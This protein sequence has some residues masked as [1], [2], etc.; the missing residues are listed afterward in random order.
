MFFYL[1]NLT[2]SLLLINLN[3]LICKF[4]PQRFYP[5][6]FY[7]LKICDQK[8]NPATAY[9]KHCK[10]ISISVILFVSIYVVFCISRYQYFLYFLLLYLMYFLL[11]YLI[12]SS[13]CILY[14]PLLYFV[15]PPFVFYVFPPFVF[16]ISSFCAFCISSLCILYFPLAHLLLL[17]LTSLRP[18]SR[19]S[20]I[21]LSIWMQITLSMFICIHIWKIVYLY[22]YL[23]TET[24][25]MRMQIT[26]CNSGQILHPNISVINAEVLQWIKDLECRANQDNA[27]QHQNRQ[28]ILMKRP[29]LNANSWPNMWS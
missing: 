9:P 10:F 17:A 4:W 25:S 14:F 27:Q 19:L 7:L 26:I 11:F 29:K 18:I 12:M 16:G 2:W 22:I 1:A 13:L 24:R 28:S 3:L 20:T 6:Y 21:T 23:T 15:F 8:L 5:K